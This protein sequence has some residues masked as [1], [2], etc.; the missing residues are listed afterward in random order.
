MRFD[1]N[2]ARGNAKHNIRTSKVKIEP[3][4]EW[5]NGRADKINEEV[6]WNANAF[7]GPIGNGTV[8]SDQLG[9]KADT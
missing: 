6:Q 7:Q 3:V 4:N 9:E 1:L 8:F 5:E 2:K